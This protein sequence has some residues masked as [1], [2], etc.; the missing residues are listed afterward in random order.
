MSSS[1][2]WRLSLLVCGIKS[3]RAFVG[4]LWGCSILSSCFGGGTN[5][6]ARLISS[7]SPS[8]LFQMKGLVDILCS[9]SEYDALPMRPGE[10]DAVKKILAHSPLTLDKPKYSDPHTK[11]N[12]LLQAHLSRA[13]LTGDLVLDQ[14]Q[15]GRRPASAASVKTP[16]GFVVQRV[17]HRA[18]NSRREPI[19]SRCFSAA[20]SQHSDS[21]PWKGGVGCDFVSYDDGMFLYVNRPQSRR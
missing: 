9:A 20:C 6:C 17:S 3:S 16:A 15:V 4:T 18:S 1:T 19:A 13:T 11:T 14:R 21:I 2:W 12:A 8:F 7:Y 5:F 10:E